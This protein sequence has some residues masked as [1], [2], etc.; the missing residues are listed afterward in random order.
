MRKVF[1][2]IGMVLGALSGLVV[3]AGIII[4]FA[5]ESKTNQ[6]FT[7][8]NIN[9]AVPAGAAPIARGQ[10]LLNAVTLCENC[11]GENLAGSIVTD[12]PGIGRVVAPNLTTGRGG[13]GAQLSDADIARVIR[14]GVKAGGTS[15]RIMPSD[16]F[17]YLSDADL[18]AVI[19]YIRSVPP[20]DNALPPS[21]WA[22]ISRILLATGQLPVL[23][24]NRVDFNAPR[25]PAPAAGATADY[26][27]YLAEIAD[28]TGCHGPGLSGGPIV[29]GAPN[30]PPAANITT[31]GAIKGWSETDFIHTIRTA[32]DPT[33]HKLSDVMPTNLF[34]RMTDDELKAIWLFLQS[35]APKEY[36]NH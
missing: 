16:K 24:A 36:G 27:H 20:V 15:V 25:L 5:S 31:A 11:H 6:T 8:P 12:N 13:V 18:G 7:T 9:I 28:C 33:G 17:F 19:A 10:Y 21:E 35:V 34:A 29:D 30:W 14:Y 22:P 1:K 2:W 4:Y 32:V 3:V 23:I 26:G